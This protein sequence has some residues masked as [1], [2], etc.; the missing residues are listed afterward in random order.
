MPALLIVGLGNP[1]VKYEKTRHNVGFMVLDFLSKALGF[2]FAFDKKF[3]AELGVLKAYNQTLYFLKPQTFMNLSGESVAPFARYFQL[4]KVLVIHDELDIPFGN[5]RFKFAG[6]SGGHNGLKSIDNAMGNEYV[7]LRF[8][9][10]RSATQSVVIPFGN[11]RFKFAGSSGGHN[12]LKSIDNAMGNEYV[13]LRFGIGRSATQSV[14]DYVLS[15][16]NTQEMKQLDILMPHLQK[17][18]LDFAQMSQDSLKDIALALQNRFG[19]NARQNTSKQTAQNKKSQTKDSANSLDS[20][21]IPLETHKIESS[22][23]FAT[24]RKG[25]EK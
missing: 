12:G 25:G 10:G 18:I 19:I 13:R 1:G 22:P 11:I 4:S 5:I 24:N 3:N 16:F 8:G 23:S 15:D 17:A 6:S 20:K 9:I 7:R 21:N 2:D 14:V